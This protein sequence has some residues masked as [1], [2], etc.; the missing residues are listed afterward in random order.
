MMEKREV[1]VAD[2]LEALGIV[3][4]K[5]LEYNTIEAPLN[6]AYP[7]LKTMSIEIDASAPKRE[8]V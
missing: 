5:W 1:D 2:V 8:V 7:L 4:A 6:Q 3:K